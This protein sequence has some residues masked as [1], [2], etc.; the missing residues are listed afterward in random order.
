ME[1][2]LPVLKLREIWN[3]CHIMTETHDEVSY[4]TPYNQ[5]AISGINQI[6]LVMAHGSNAFELNG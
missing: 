6:E 4:W 2:L 1:I 5:C 3:V